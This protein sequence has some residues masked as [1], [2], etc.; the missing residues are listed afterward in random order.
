[1]L[2][3]RRVIQ[4]TVLTL[5]AVAGMFELSGI[6]ERFFGRKRFRFIYATNGSDG[7]DAPKETSPNVANAW[8]QGTT[9]A[10]DGIPLPTAL[11]RSQQP[12]A[13]WLL[14]F[15]GNDQRQFKLGMQVLE[16]IDAGHGANLCALAYRGYEGSN[17]TPERAAIEQDALLAARDLLARESLAPRQL[18]LVGFSIGAYYAASVAAALSDENETPGSLTLFAPAY[19]LVMVRPSPWERLDPGDDMQMS[20]FLPRVRCRSLVL[21][22][23]QDEA[24]QGTTQGQ[25]AARQLADAHYVE[26]QG[27]GHEALLSHDAALSTAHAWLWGKDTQGN[28]P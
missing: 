24:F 28:V 13:P 23:T 17:G 26:F 19:D 7:S 8:T 22:G 14:Y 12:D 20:G 21:Q 15:P 25:A 10:Q 18:H 5:G 6:R 16:G 3:R 27:L 2:A 9:R 4:G 11:K 1:M